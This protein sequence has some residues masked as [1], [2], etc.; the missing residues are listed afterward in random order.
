M[1]ES[2]SVSN[3]EVP[4]PKIEGESHFR[5]DEVMPCVFSLSNDGKNSHAPM[6]V[7]LVYMVSCPKVE[8]ES[9]ACESGTK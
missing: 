1:K 9:D 7:V 4:V 8:V 3:N 2:L 5:E 6:K